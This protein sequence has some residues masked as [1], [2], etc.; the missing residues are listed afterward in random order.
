V[1]CFLL[2]ETAFGVWS[3][4]D[5]I[6]YF[7]G[8]D[9]KQLAVPTIEWMFYFYIAALFAG[10]VV[11][12]L[13]VY[14]AYHIYKEMKVVLD[15]M[16]TGMQAGQGGGGGP[17][18]GNGYDVQPPSSQREDRAPLWRHAESHPA[19]SVPAAAAPTASSGGLGGFQAFTGTG[20][21]LGE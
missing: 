21:K 16:V 8:L 2:L 15:E 19:P 6:F 5:L 3:L 10:P 18:M 11:Y 20:R 17:L 13:T 1:L 14:F 7:A 9:I 4:L 12:S